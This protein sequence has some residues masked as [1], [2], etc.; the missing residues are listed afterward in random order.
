MS[1]VGNVVFTII[2]AVEM[3]IKLFGFGIKK[4]M[5]DYF[6]VFDCVIVCIS[7]LELCLQSENSGLSVLRAF[8]LA[9]VFKIIKS[10][11]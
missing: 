3:V 8:R 11:V 2:F 5:S 1:E 9:R 7:V 10:F 4:Y 6:N